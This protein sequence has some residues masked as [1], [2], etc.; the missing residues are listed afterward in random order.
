MCL[1][2]HFRCVLLFVT[3]WTVAHQAPLSMGSS[4]QEYWVGCHALLQGI[5]PTQGSNPHLQHLL[6]CRRILHDWATREA[7]IIIFVNVNVLVTQSCLTFCDPMDCSPPGSSVCRWN[8]PGKNT[9]VDHLALLQGIFLT[10]RL[11]PS[12]R[13]CRQIL[14]HLSHEESP[15]IILPTIKHLF[16]CS[17]IAVSP[18]RFS[19]FGKMK[20]KL[21]LCTSIRW[22]IM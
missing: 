9:G 18:Q 2:G 8:S 13:H 20:V 7:L 15:I 17:I 12:L 3:L 11:N 21:P 22:T 10:Q 1:F 19:V 14:Y 5:F 16:L 6:H 4:R